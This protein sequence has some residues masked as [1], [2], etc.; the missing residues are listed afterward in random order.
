VT[1][2]SVVDVVDAAERFAKRVPLPTCNGC[3]QGRFDY[4][5]EKWMDA[6][7]EQLRFE[8]GSHIYW[9]MDVTNPGC[10]VVRQGEHAPVIRIANVVNSVNDVGGKQ[11][12]LASFS[13]AAS[14]RIRTSS[15]VPAPLPVADLDRIGDLLAGMARLE[16]EVRHLQQMV[17]ARDAAVLEQLTRLRIIANYFGTAQ[18]FGS[19]D[20]PLF[21][22]CDVVLQRGDKPPDIRDASRP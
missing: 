2:W 14:E 18:W 8:S 5:I 1:K 6:L 21:G 13:D 19:V 16:G 4:N 3:P 12:V 20:L 17:A 22:S 10:Y 15:M 9:M 11:L 7:V